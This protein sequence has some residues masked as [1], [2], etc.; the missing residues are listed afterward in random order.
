VKASRQSSQLI[1]REP[2]AARRDE[3]N[4]PWLCAARC[5]AHAARACR[6][7]PPIVLRGPDHATGVNSDL[8]GRAAGGRRLIAV[9]YADMVGYSPPRSMTTSVD[10]AKQW[11]EI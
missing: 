7:A 3:G 4:S 8:A 11:V 6:G 2:T 9:V 10:K 5:E 1:T